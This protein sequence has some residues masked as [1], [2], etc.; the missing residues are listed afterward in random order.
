M[1]RAWGPVGKDTEELMD[2]ISFVIPIYNEEGN[3]E[4]L[5]EELSRVAET[6]GSSISR[7]CLWTMPAPIAVC[8]YHQGAGLISRT[9]SLL[10]L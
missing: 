5:F 4:R 9:G 7:S 1:F 2:K 3:V 8:R 6:S 10:V